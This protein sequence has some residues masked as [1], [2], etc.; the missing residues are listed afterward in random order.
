LRTEADGRGGGGGAGGTGCG[1]A[2]TAS[3]VGGCGGRKDVP[4][5]SQALADISR[6]RLARFIKRGRGLVRDILVSHTA[7]AL[8]VRV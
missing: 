8:K 5:L 2:A 6:A 1:G 7:R 3:D 4:T